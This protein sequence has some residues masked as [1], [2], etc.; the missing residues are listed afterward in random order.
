MS[1]RI[2]LDQWSILAAA[3]E[4][5]DTQGFEAVTLAKLA[6]R[7]NIRTPSLYNHVAGLPELRKLLALD[8]LNLLVDWLNRRMEEKDGEEDVHR[9]CEAYLQFAREH[10]G[11]YEAIQR[12]PEPDDPLLTQAANR[13]VELALKTLAPYE[14]SQEEAV[15]AVRGMRSLLHGFVLL[16]RQ[17]GFGLPLDL[18]ETFRFALTA[19]TAGLRRIGT[20]PA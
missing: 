1:P 3:A 9:Y 15:H 19:Y 13:V 20:G 17:G 6:Q 12:A 16:E 4:V 10:P 7:L 5:A 11:L 2:G 8:G 14:L 18:D